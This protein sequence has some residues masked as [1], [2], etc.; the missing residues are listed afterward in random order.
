MKLDIDIEDQVA[1]AIVGERRI[2]A[3]T[4]VDFRREILAV[5]PE[6]ASHLKLDL[7]AVAFIDSSGIGALVSVLK[8]VGRAGEVDLCGVQSSVMT[9][10]EMTHMDRIFSFKP[11]IER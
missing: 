1:I 6:K 5:V 3:A 11:A 7:S 2:D 8:A 9:V 4:A 10:F